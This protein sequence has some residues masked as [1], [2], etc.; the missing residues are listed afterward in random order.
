M[1][2]QK[3]LVNA[4]SAQLGIP[5]NQVQDVVRTLFSIIRETVNNGEPVY[6]AGMGTFK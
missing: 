1:N 5:T 4:V 6:L 3:D 2:T